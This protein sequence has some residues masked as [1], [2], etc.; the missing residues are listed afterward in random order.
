[1]TE[2]ELRRRIAPIKVAAA[3]MR[4]RATAANTDQARTPYSDAGAVPVPEAEWGALVDNYLGGE[5]GDHCA[6]LTPAFA[7]A[8]AAAM[9]DLLERVERQWHRYLATDGQELCELLSW[10]RI[11]LSYLLPEQVPA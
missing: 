1:M 3:R 9:D 11:A 8:V 5:I 4:N 10:E 7:L 6:A 2:E